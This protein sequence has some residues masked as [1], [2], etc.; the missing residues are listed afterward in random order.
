MRELRGLVYLAWLTCR[1]QAWARKSLVAAVLIIMLTMATAIWTQRGD[2]LKE[3]N[4]AV[5]QTKQFS[6]MTNTVVVRLFVSFLLP[7]L[8][9][10]Y[11][12]A[13]IGEQREDR[14]LVYTLIRPLSRWRIYLASALGI[15][16]LVLLVTLGGFAMVCSAGGQAGGLAWDNYWSAILRAALTYSALFLLFG[17][18][19][20]RPVI[21]AVVYAFL[22]EALLGGMPGTIK[23]LAVSFYAN[24]M[25]YERA[26]LYDIK[27]E[28]PQFQGIASESAMFYLDIIALALFLLGAV[29]FQRREYRDL[30]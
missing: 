26:A 17:A 29:W 28:L 20:P 6:F 10:T 18:V 16:P 24:S 4:E 13:A 11:A 8:V 22:I 19:F 23:R 7:I 27:P 25:I 3:A 12:T 14:T 21:L 15:L 1:R 5:R 9:L 30:A 2:F